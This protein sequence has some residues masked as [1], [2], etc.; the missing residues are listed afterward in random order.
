MRAI[1]PRCF[2]VLLLLHVLVGCV[3]TAGKKPPAVET[4]IGA[5]IERSV[6]E[7]IERARSEV[8]DFPDLPD[9]EPVDS[10]V[11][12]E[13]SDTP[14]ALSERVAEE[15]ELARNPYVITAHKPNFLLPA[16]HSTGLNTEAYADTNLDVAKDFAPV[17]V[18]FQISFKTQLNQ[19]D[20][21]LKDDSLSVG[22]TLEAWWQLYSD[23][24][25]SPFRETNY[26]PEIF[27]LKPLLWGPFGGSTA[28]LLG[29]EHQSNGQIQALSRSWNRLYTGLIYERDNLLVR[30]RPWYR[31][32]ESPRESPDD[33]RGDDNPDILDFMGHGDLSIGLRRNAHDLHVLLRGNPSTGNGAIEVDWTFPLFAELRGFVHY[34]NGYG[35]SLIDFDHRQ[36][37][38][39]VGVALTSLF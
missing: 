3:S 8:E 35:D 12:Q 34:F 11:A 39:G 32:P 7:R 24:L 20:L 13:R 23:E 33:P 37:R 30:L 14:G 18:Q 31:I 38:L 26:Q 36:Q 15:R 9:L 27:Y 22:F 29:F 25:S 16:V 10:S 28:V 2:T 17:E 5:E 19:S 6:E 1:A 4:G 21:F